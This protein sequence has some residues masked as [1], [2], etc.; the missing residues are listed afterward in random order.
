MAYTRNQIIEKLNNFLKSGCKWETFY[1]EK[2]INNR[3]K[4]SDTKKPYSEV[5]SEWLLDGKLEHLEKIIK[6]E[7]ERTY[8]TEAHNT[9]I[10]FESTREEEILA[11]IMHRNSKK[12]DK[13]YDFGKIIDYQTPIKATSDKN[14]AG[15]KAG[16]IDLLAEQD[17]TIRFIELKRKKSTETL[18]RCILEIYTY[19]KQVDHKKLLKDFGKKENTEIILTV[20]VFESSEAWK[21]YEDKTYSKTKELLEKL[22]V[23]VI[24]LPDNMEE[25]KELERK[26]DRLIVKN[27]KK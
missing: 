3:G 10:Y 21:N 17:D 12:D 4:T 25:Q 9:E 2:F 22:K 27:R 20:L 16:K 15:N 8:K 11:K 6:I 1:K 23:E 5:I 19:Y 24:A 7:R 26:I 14:K 13:N 18:L